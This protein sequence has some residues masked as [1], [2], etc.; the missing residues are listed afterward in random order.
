MWGTYIEPGSG[1]MTRPA[2]PVIRGSPGD[3]LLRTKLG[4][5]E[6]QGPCANNNT[7]MF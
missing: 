4:G 1:V 7:E 2:G 5:R 6:R 3:L